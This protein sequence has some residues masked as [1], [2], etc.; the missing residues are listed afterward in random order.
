VRKLAIVIT[1]MIGQPSR[2][3]GVG[4]QVLRAHVMMLSAHHAT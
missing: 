1:A 4:V 3:R 2:V